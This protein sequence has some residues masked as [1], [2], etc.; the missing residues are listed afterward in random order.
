LSGARSGCWTCHYILSTSVYLLCSMSIYYWP[1]IEIFSK[2]NYICYVYFTKKIVKM[3]NAPISKDN[4]VG[5]NSEKRPGLRSGNLDFSHGYA[6][7]YELGQN[8]QS[9]CASTFWS[10]KWFGD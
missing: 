10:I 9:L 2:F 1:H 6:H 5:K 8:Q 4:T 3:F 7:L